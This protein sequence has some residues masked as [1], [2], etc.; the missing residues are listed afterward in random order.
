MYLLY[1]LVCAPRED[2]E[3]LGL[4]AQQREQEPAKPNLKYPASH[5]VTQPPPTKQQDD[6]CE[7]V[8]GG[9]KKE[10]CI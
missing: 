10:L 6:R 1:Y 3:R 5:S 7:G 2:T 8:G 4:S 9:L